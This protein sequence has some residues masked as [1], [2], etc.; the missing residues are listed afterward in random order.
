M[1]G[2]FTESVVEV[3]ALAWIEGLG[4]THL[5]GPGISIGLVEDLSEE[6]TT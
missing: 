2:N 5:H 1:S 3:A 6:M 4:Y